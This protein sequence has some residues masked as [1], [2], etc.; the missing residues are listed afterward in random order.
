MAWKAIL[1]ELTRKGPMV[2]CT[3]TF[4]NDDPPETFVEPIHGDLDKDKVVAIAKVRLAQLAVRDAGFATLKP[5]LVEI[6]DDVAP[7]A[8]D[9]FFAKLSKLNAAPTAI[10]SVSPL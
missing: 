10:P 8:A 9:E 7:T 3:L 5:G 6:P 4:D 2:Y 1:G